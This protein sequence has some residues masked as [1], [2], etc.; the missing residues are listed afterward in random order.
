[1]KSAPLQRLFL[2]AHGTP[3]A[4][5]LRAAY[6]AAVRFVSG[7]LIGT[8]GVRAVYLTSGLLDEPVYGL[9]DIDLIVVVDDLDGYAVL[10]VVELAAYLKTIVPM[11]EPPE[12]IGVYAIADLP[13]RLAASPLLQYRLLGLPRRLLFGRDLLAELRP[14]ASPAAQ[15]L[16]ELSDTWAQAV[17][18]LAQRPGPER[19]YQ[20]TKLLARAARALWFARTGE[21]RARRRDALAT[22][23]G[24]PAL[25]LQDV[26]LAEAWAALH[27][28]IAAALPALAPNAPGGAARPFPRGFISTDPLE[29]ACER[30]QRIVRLDRPPDREACE[31]LLASGDEVLVEIGDVLYPL[32]RPGLYGL[33]LRPLRPE[34]FGD[35][36]PEA[37][38]AEI[39][40]ALAARRDTLRERLAGRDPYKLADDAWVRLFFNALETTRPFSSPADAASELSEEADRETVRGLA[41]WLADPARGELSRERFHASLALARRALGLPPSA[42]TA[43]P[44]RLS[45]VVCTRDRA[46]PL[47]RFLGRVAAQRR[48]ADEVVVV[49]NG[50][51]DA[52]AS[53]AERWRD[54]LPIRYVHHAPPGVPGARN[55]GAAAASGDVVVYADDDTEPDADWLAAIEEPF[56]R[57]PHVGVVG[58]EVLQARAQRGPI[59]DFFRRYMGGEA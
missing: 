45:V 6:A 59:A 43:G 54:R 10:R 36:V 47:D 49:D 48:A 25:H 32:A 50:S 38:I 23:E 55:A 2:R 9:A 31:R 58:G 35:P 14:T 8:P 33:A 46:G 24:D 27:R 22:L 53:V 28:L 44:L 29:L 20:W 57:D 5:A 15:A 52:T 1:M 37:R 4:L 34:A 30:P 3:A 40:A 41:A 39:Q 13:G 16:A 12:A 18:V 42:P 19:G 21:L 26:G 7:R 56:L 11:L 51:R 17:R